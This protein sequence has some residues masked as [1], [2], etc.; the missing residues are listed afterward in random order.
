[1]KAKDLVGKSVV[2]YETEEIGVIVEANDP[3]QGSHGV[4]IDCLVKWEDGSESWVDASD[5]EIECID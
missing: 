1:M 3:P 2:S 5:V 4:G